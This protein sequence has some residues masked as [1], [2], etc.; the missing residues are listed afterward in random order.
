MSSNSPVNFAAIPIT[1]VHLSHLNGWDAYLS[2]GQAK[3]LTQSFCQKTPN[4]QQLQHIKSLA[5]LVAFLV[6]EEKT[7]YSPYHTLARLR[8]C[9]SELGYA[10]LEG[11]I[12]K[13]AKKANF[14][15]PEPDA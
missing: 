5:G 12:K 10:G 1:Q 15:G 14:P 6:K 3:S 7:Y 9:I 8:K 11:Q 4:I 13:S 2:E